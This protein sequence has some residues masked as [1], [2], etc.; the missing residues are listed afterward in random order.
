MVSLAIQLLLLA[1]AL[2]VNFVIPAVYGLEA[3]GAFIQANILVFL[4][5]KLTDLMTEPLISRVAPVSVFPLSLMLSLA[6]WV[7]FVLTDRIVELGSTALLAA[8]LLS[9]CAMLSMHALGFRRLLLVYLLAFSGAFLCLLAATH[10][11]KA[12]FSIRDILFWTNLIPATVVSLVLLRKNVVIPDVQALKGLMAIVF[13]MAPEN[14]AIS[15]VF[16]LFTNL[17]PYVFSR[18]LP[19]ADL[20]LFRVITALVQSATTIFPI[21]TKTLFVALVNSDNKSDYVRLLLVWSA[22]YFAL[23]GLGALF[24]ANVRPQLLPYLALVTSLPT[25]YWTVMLERYLQA[26][27]LRRALI[28]AN[29]QIGAVVLAG[30]IFVQSVEAATYCYAFGLALYAFR[31]LSINRSILTLSNF[32]P[33]VFLS[34]VVVWLQSYSILYSVAYFIGVMLFVVIAFRPGPDD[35]RKMRVNL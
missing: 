20:G 33:I 11:G 26:A 8:M 31:L 24:L 19:L 7:V 3:Y 2:L 23:V 21:N 13:R 25:L 32:A 18:T 28:A 30:A 22:L 12:T 9:S 17:L 29:L 4:I 15:L 10:A 35:I 6:V 27:G 14:F 5:Q 34:P 16:N 1:A